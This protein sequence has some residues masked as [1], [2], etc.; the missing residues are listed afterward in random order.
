MYNAS[1]RRPRNL[2]RHLYRGQRVE[3]PCCGGRWRR[4]ASLSG[5]RHA[6]CPGCFTAERHRLLWLYF[7]RETDLLHTHHRVMHIAPEPSLSRLLAG[8]TNLDYLSADL[9]PSRGAMETFDIMDIP[10]ADDTFDVVIC[11]HVLEHVRDDRVA[12]REIRRVLAPGGVAY[13]PHP[14]A[15]DRAT[16]YEDAT[17]VTASGRRRAFGQEDHLRLYGRDFTTRLEAA[18]FSVTVRFYANELLPAER[19]RYGVQDEPIY[20]CR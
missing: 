2:R 4:F 11:S 3:C 19:R 8:R 15:P 16:T 9:D 10:K 17:I 14:V 20:V 13:L 18:G 5:R 6:L 7:D 12:M 1:V